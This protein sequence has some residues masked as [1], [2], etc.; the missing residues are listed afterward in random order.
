MSLDLLLI[1][2]GGA[3]TVYQGLADDLA[4]IEPP[5]WCRL[6][7]GYVRDRGY[8]V[9]I[10]DAAAENLDAEAVAE[11]AREMRPRL[12]CVAVFGH[13]VSASTQTMPPAGEICSAIRGKIGTRLIMVGGHPAALPERTFAEEE[14]DYVCTGE[15]P[16]TIERLLAGARPESVPGLVWEGGKT[17]P[18]P[19]L[20]LAERGLDPFEGITDEPEL[21]AMLAREV[22]E[23]EA[24]W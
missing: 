3:R 9:R 10:L 19:L 7:A 13:W 16:A 14:V 12:G 23:A 1:N 6:I 5:L 24:D 20:D 4:A 8:D 18:A 2:P 17:P 21:D 11:R 15:G 22:S